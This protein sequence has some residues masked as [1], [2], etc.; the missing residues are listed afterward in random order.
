MAKRTRSPLNPYN[1]PLRRNAEVRCDVPFAD[2]KL[3]MFIV[4]DFSCVLHVAEGRS[5]IVS[6][7]RSLLAVAG[8]H[9]GVSKDQLVYDL[10]G[11]LWAFASILG[12][13]RPIKDDKF[14]TFLEQRLDFPLSDLSPQI[15]D[16]T[17]RFFSLASSDIDQPWVL[18]QTELDFAQLRCKVVRKL[19]VSPYS[20]EHDAGQPAVAGDSVRRTI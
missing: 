5:R 4:D 18:R 14:Y 19:T 13:G 20:G 17:I 12:F 3:F 16:R 2:G 9:P 15:E 8:R 7:R 6:S 1:G 10:E 11:I